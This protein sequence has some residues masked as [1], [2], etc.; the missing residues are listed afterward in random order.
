MHKNKLFCIGL[1]FLFLG[2][3]AVPITQGNITTGSNISIYVNNTFYVGGNGPDNY[4]TIQ[5]AIDDAE[6]GDIV[7]VYDEGSPYY[8]NIVVDKSIKLIGENRNTTLIDGNNKDDV[9]CITA[10]HVYLHGFN[11]TNCGN[12]NFDS[13]IEIK[14]DYNTISNNNIH[15]NEGDRLVSGGILINS[16]YNNTIFF[17]KIYSNKYDGISIINSY[18]NHIHQNKIFD[19][20]RLGIT[21]TN[22]SN[23]LIEENDIY[24]NYCGICLYPRST[25]NVV[26]NNY[27]YYHPCCG[28]A[29]KQFSDYNLII[30]NLVID[31]IAH[32]IMLGPGP[33]SYNIVELNTVTGCMAFPWYPNAAIVLENAFFNTISKNNIFN[34]Y[35]DVIVNS[36]FVNSWANNYWDNYL[37]FGPKFIMGWI[38]LSFKTEIII[39]WF[40]IDWNPAE[41]PYDITLENPDISQFQ[42]IHQS[43]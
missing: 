21:L 30:S 26:K 28:I 22:S 43:E 39:P 3:I 16:S 12:N 35:Q 14:S 8:E 40:N 11:L 10:D 20:K 41:E 32:G 27:I 1:T 18:Y 42:S 6:S 5:G 17:N 23:N 33:T 4:T 19:N 9:L 15:N 37:G 29:L 7:F 34:N 24:E 38:Y 2:V 25:H 13:G 31:N 36:S